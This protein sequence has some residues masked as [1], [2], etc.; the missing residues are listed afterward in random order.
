IGSESRAAAA[1]G[2]TSFMEMPNTVPQTLTQD[3][4]AEKYQMG[5]ESSRVNYSFFMGVSNHN[6]EEVLKTDFNEVCGLK[7]FMGSSTGDMLVDDAEVLEAIFKNA[8]GLI[9]VHCEDESR[10]RSNLAKAKEKFGDDI[11]MEQHPVIRDAE[12]CFLSSSRA[13]SLAKKHNSR[14]HVLHISTAKELELFSA[15]KTTKGKRITAEACVHHLWF[16]DEDY[17]RKGSH[18]KWNPAVKSKVDREAL[19]AALKTDK[20]DVLATDHAPHTSEEKDNPYL[21]CP[22]GGPL[23]QHALVALLELHLQGHI[24]IETIVKKACHM[25]AEIFGVVDRGY[26]R[27]GFFADIVLVDLH[28]P[29]TVSKENLLYKCGWSPFEGQSFQ[30]KVKHTFVNG[31]P[32]YQDGIIDDSFRGKRLRFAH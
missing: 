17:G 22:S 24:D 29:W 28:D 23:V 26:L 13:V 6:I 16:C 30:S 7:I 2:I 27:E 14:L 15:E 3:L 19:R 8:R 4:L 21:S 5:A 10:V 11:P 18:I 31:H 32:V 1:G 9:A 25:P 12:A 20:I